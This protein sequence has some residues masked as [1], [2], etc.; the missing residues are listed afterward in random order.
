[1]WHASKNNSWQPSATLIN[2]KLRAKIIA[3][4]R[5]FFAAR[6]VLEVETPILSPNGSTD[7][8]IASFST[9]YHLDTNQ[10]KSLLFYLQTSPEFYMKR[11]LTAGSGSIYQIS[12]AFRDQ[13]CGR[14][15]Q[16]EFS[17]LEW[18]RTE[19]DHHALMQEMTE[20]LELILGTKK[21]EL[22]TYAAIFQKYLGI[23]PHIATIK[24]FKNSIENYT[25]A[26][27]DE[28]I[29]STD[30]DLWRNTLL[31][32]VIE[33]RLKEK[34][35][36]VFIYDFP[37]SQ[38]ALAKIGNLNDEGYKIAE[39]FEVY[40]SGIELANGF[41]ELNDAT[42]QR[43]R[44]EQDLTSR[45]AL[46]LPQIPIDENL[47]AALEYGLPKCAGVALGLDRLVMLAA[48]ATQIGEVIS[49]EFSSIAKT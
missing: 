41:H 31:T 35:Y 14:L 39:R 38:A 21:R 32:H 18:Y 12:K 37:A 20:L 3:Q 44:F 25:L 24:E 2:L 42:E 16:P 36:P 22:Y 47:L 43:Q 5:N 6:D 29:E 40:I 23:N 30:I 27:S 19:F 26:L 10:R 33:P 28:I 17:M 49:F 9:N 8:H 48:K 15:H 46:G 11:L 1:M 34:N 13:E 4:I 7:V 45:K